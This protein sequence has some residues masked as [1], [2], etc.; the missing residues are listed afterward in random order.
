MSNIINGSSIKFS[1]S[2]Y[3]T[4]AITYVKCNIETSIFLII[5]KQVPIQTR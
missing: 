2:I 5:M 4:I 3:Q 1:D